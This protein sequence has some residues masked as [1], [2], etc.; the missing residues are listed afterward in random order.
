MKPPWTRTIAFIFESG[1]AFIN[2]SFLSFLVCFA[3]REKRD[4]V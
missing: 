3:N 2:I 1:L 4:V